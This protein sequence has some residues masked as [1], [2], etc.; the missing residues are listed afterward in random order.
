MKV[1]LCDWCGE[2]CADKTEGAHFDVS[3]EDSYTG[4]EKVY[5]LCLGCVAKIRALVPTCIELC[6]NEKC[7]AWGV[8]NH[9]KHDV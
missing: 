7:P 5:E 3:I 9:A 1:I 8:Y 2:E 6:Q 4:R